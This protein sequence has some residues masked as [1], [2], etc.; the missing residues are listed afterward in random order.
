MTLTPSEPV[1]LG[2]ASLLLRTHQYATHPVTLAPG[3]TLLLAEN[4][5]FAI[6]LVEFGTPGE[7]SGAEA[8]GAAELL[9][10]L[11]AEAGAKRW[12]AY[13]VLLSPAA[14]TADAMPES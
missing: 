6:G 8:S 13:L 7:L 10:R 9:D 4:D 2:P 1:L 5:F 3:T 12:D 14:L 11:S